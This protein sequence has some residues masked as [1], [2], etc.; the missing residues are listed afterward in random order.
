MD[1]LVRLDKAFLHK[2]AYLA[3]KDN[4]P[5]EILSL[6]EIDGD[7]AAASNADAAGG[8]PVFTPNGQPVGRVTS[9]AYG[10]HVGM[11]L[12]IGYVDP[13][14]ASAGDAVDI[15]ILGKPHRGRIC[16]PRL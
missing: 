7:A 12:A 16:R 8:E 13:A 10:Y 15:F 3:I 5:R 4:K 14:V 11:S 2:D 6:F 9:G 1:R